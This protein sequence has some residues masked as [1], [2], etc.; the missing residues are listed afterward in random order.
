M[1]AAIRRLDRKDEEDSKTVREAR[2]LQA[3]GDLEGAYRKAS[4]LLVSERTSP[5]NLKEAEEVE[6]ALLAPRQPELFGVLAKEGL[7]PDETLRTE[8]EKLRSGTS[9]PGFRASVDGELYRLARGTL[10]GKVVR[11]DK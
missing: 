3:S 1:N 2:Q 6:R 8:L 5:E 7:V 9:H 10:G 4:P 11:S